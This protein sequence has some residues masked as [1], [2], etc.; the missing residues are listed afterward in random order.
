MDGNVF[1][2]V[3]VGS[4]PE[5]FESDAIT[6]ALIPG[7]SEIVPAFGNFSRLLFFYMRMESVIIDDRLIIDIKEATVVRV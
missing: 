1:P 6:R 7:N 3:R 2:L 5:K 4:L